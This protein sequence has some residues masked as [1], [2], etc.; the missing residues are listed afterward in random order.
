MYSSR[1]LHLLLLNRS[2]DLASVLQHIRSL[3]YEERSGNAIGKGSPIPL[4]QGTGRELLVPCSNSAGRERSNCVSFEI[5]PVT[6]M[7][8]FTGLANENMK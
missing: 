3:R 6:V 8:K 7:S 5:L 2:N 1:G 4:I